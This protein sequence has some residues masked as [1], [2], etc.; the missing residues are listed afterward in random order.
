MSAYF[1]VSVYLRDTE[2]RNSSLEVFNTKV[3][4]LKLQQLIAEFGVEAPAIH[5]ADAVKAAFFSQGKSHK[6]AQNET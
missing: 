4:R 2:D 5:E 1:E 6:E 3:R